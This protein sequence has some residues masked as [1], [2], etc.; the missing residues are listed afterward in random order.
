MH[1]CHL[2]EIYL[3]NIE[4]TTG[5][6]IGNKIVDKIVKPAENLRDVAEEIFI[7]PEKRE[8][9]LNKEKYYKNGTP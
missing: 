8:E 3:T 6:F 9:I 5:E 2:R 1:F 7:S 4:T